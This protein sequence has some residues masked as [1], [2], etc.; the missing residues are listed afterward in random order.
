[1][2]VSEIMKK[3]FE[4][5]M[6]G[7]SFHNEQHELFKFLNYDGFAMLHRHQAQDEYNSFLDIT[8]CFIDNINE[9]VKIDYPQRKSTVPESFYHANRF[10]VTPQERRR[11]TKES[12]DK[13]K[14]W[15]EKAIRTYIDAYQNL[16]DIGN[17]DLAD[18]VKKL[19]RDDSKEIRILEKLYIELENVEY[20]AHHLERIQPEILDKYC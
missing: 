2:T 13:Y 8:N 10:E 1:M 14:E 18:K 19:I 3:V 4:A 12:F 17:I 16:I 7:I 11:Y 20:G 15:E 5:E 6:E 9:L